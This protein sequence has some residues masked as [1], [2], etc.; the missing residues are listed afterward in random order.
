MA[1]LTGTDVTHVFFYPEGFSHFQ[2]K[3]IQKI[4][5][6]YLHLH[7]AVLLFYLLT[8][9]LQR[10]AETARKQKVC[11]AH[12]NEQMWFPVLILHLREYVGNCNFKP[13]MRF[14]SR[15]GAHDHTNF[16]EEIKCE[17]PIL[18]HSDPP[19]ELEAHPA[20]L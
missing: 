15:C 14:D 13:S 5:T 2:R 20:C 19:S 1:L 4:N 7:W 10:V 9:R 16:F 6:N 18:L 12:Y 8:Q 3:C 17:L 11:G